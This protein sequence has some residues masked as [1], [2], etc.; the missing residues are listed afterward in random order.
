M[1]KI[2]LKFS[3]LLF[4]ILFPKD[5]SLSFGL[6]DI[7]LRLFLEINLD[8]PKYMTCLADDKQIEL[9][10]LCF[11]DKKIKNLVCEGYIEIPKTDQYKFSIKT[12]GN[13]KLIIDKSL[14]IQT[15]KDLETKVYLKKGNYKL[16][17]IYKSDSTADF[18]VYIKNVIPFKPKPRC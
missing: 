16:K 18:C 2:L 6:S 8:F 17:L 1:R 5:N 4:L 12:K 10:K 9:K 13:F 14:F 11:Q 3:I 7:L 15:D